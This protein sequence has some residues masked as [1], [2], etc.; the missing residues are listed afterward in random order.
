MAVATARPRAK[1]SAKAPKLDLTRA[2]RVIYY[3]TD[4][5]RA[6]KFYEETLGLPLAY[7]A[8]DGWASFQL[9]GIELSIHGG[10][11]KSQKSD[12]AY[13]GFGVTNFDAAY[14]ALRARGVK[15]GEITSPCSGTR[16][17]CFHDPDGNELG[18][19]GK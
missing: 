19:E 7:P 1:K 2:Q 3:V 14:A 4:F 17:S 5:N 6:V 8:E 13:F 12:G 15:M 18:I 9:K 10:R 16:F 11:G